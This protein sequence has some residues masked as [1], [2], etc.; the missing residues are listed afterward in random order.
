[1]RYADDDYDQSNCIECI[2][3]YGPYQIDRS[4]AVCRKCNVTIDKCFKCQWTY[5]P[6]DKHEKAYR[7]YFCTNCT[8]GYYPEGADQHF[9][10]Y[11]YGNSC[12]KCPPYCLDCA[13][14]KYCKLCKGDR[15]VFLPSGYEEIQSIRLCRMYFGYKIMYLGVFLFIII[16]IGVCTANL[17]CIRVDSTRTLFLVSDKAADNF[18]GIDKLMTPE[19]AYDESIDAGD[20]RDEQEEE[21]GLAFKRNKRENDF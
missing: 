4:T 17:L 10:P 19:D 13:H 3:G 5:V 1:M 11:H 21:E 20:G 6:A 12:I 8:F 18:Q 16:T 9:A 7:K 15:E 2:T 14:A